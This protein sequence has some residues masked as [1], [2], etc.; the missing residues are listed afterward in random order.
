MVDP[1]TVGPAKLP[2]KGLFVKQPLPIAGAAASGAPPLFQVKEPASFLL[3]T[4]SKV[5]EAVRARLAAVSCQRMFKAGGL[6]FIAT[7]QS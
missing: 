1:M 6:L 7:Q 3:A 4:M 5:T 2:G